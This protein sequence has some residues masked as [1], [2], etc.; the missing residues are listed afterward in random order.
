MVLILHPG[1]DA[2]VEVREKRAHRG[3]SVTVEGLYWMLAA[4][5][6]VADDLARKRAKRSRRG[7]K[8]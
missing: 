7:K 4:R 8:K 5:K 1:D 2:I 3:L 6:V